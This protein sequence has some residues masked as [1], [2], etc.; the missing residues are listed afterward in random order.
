MRILLIFQNEESKKKKGK[1]SAL[2]EITVQPE[3]KTNTG[4]TMNSQRVWNQSYFLNSVAKLAFTHSSLGRDT[5]SFKL[6]SFQKVRKEGKS[7]SKKKK[8]GPYK[9]GV[10][11]GVKLKE[12]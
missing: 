7:F 3:E 6:S 10:T 1:V 11:Q 4:E 8:F 9:S 2:Q 5:F 12:V